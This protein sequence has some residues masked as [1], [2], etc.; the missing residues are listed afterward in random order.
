[1]HA[2]EDTSVAPVAQFLIIIEHVSLFKLL[3]ADILVSVLQHWL[4]P[5]RRRRKKYM[6]KST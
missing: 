3:A 2:L 6:K 5:V 4:A 1:M